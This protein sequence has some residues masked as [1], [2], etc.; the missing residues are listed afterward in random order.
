MNAPQQGSFPL[1][2]QVAYNA[3]DVHG[4]AAVERF[5]ER[6]TLTLWF[7]TLVDHNEDTKL[8]AKLSG[9]TATQYLLSRLVQHID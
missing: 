1:C 4:V 7:S 8:L 9:V 6:F 2:L 5:G 3:Q